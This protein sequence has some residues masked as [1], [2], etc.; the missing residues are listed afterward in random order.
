ME[1]LN[2][3]KAYVV[4]EKF[5]LNM[6]EGSTRQSFNVSVGDILY[7]DGIN[8]TVGGLKGPAASLKTVISLGWLVEVKNPAA[9]KASA[10]AAPAKA[11][12]QPPPYLAPTAAASQGISPEQRSRRT[13]SA[14]EYGKEVSAVRGNKP[15]DNSNTVMSSTSESARKGRSLVSEEEKSV[16]AVRAVTGAASPG[17]AE[18]LGLT[19]KASAPA[20]E[21][22]VNYIQPGGRQKREVVTDDSQQVDTGRSSRATVA[23][24]T[25]EINASNSAGE[26]DIELAPATTLAKKGKGATSRASVSGREITSDQQEVGAVISTRRATAAQNSADMTKVSDAEAKSEPPPMRTASISDG[27]GQVVAGTRKIREQPSEAG[28]TSKVSVGPSGDMVVPKATTSATD[29][30][31]I[32]GKTASVSS[33]DGDI[34]DPSNYLGLG[35]KSDV[36]QPIVADAP[37]KKAPV[38]K[39]IASAPKKEA[40][41]PKVVAPAVEEQPVDDLVFDDGQEAPEI[42]MVL[43]HNG[44][45][46]PARKDI[47]ERVVLP[48]QDV[49]EE[50]Y[51][52]LNAGLEEQPTSAGAQVVP[53]NE[54]VPKDY[55]ETLVV[56]GFPWAKTPHT[57]K[58]QYILGKRVGKKTV[59][60]CNNLSI[61]KLI[62]E[63]KGLPPSVLQAADQRL[64]ILKAK[65]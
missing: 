52:D 45:L 30:A 25:V 46:V 28:F 47:K 9:A 26:Q 56:G 41:A 19:K 40:P 3:N 49:Q 59:G 43:D 2:P 8:V 57:A 21:K 44:K 1:S 18:A 20:A 24:S 31:I 27:E 34:Y 11:A 63:Q 39:K 38:T 50:D 10:K 6:G 12:L 61:L 7:F 16:S 14:E 33:S 58:I 13:V 53:A 60:G 54:V 48:D 51:S 65:K 55:L 22:P 36:F 62:K 5:A 17:K 35:K 29:T 42:P 37:V 32:M 15:S 23:Q 64:E 4:K